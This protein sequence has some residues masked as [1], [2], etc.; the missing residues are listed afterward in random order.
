MN[1]FPRM[2]RLPPYAFNVVGD[3]K[4]ELRH[5]NIDI[6]DLSMGNPDP[7]TPRHIVDKMVEAAQKPVNHR[8]SV[9]RGIPNLR[10][11]ICDWYRRRFGVELN[12]DTQAIAT[13][14]AKEGLSH[15]CLAMLEP[16]DVVFAPDPTYPIHVYAPVICGADVRRV[17]IGEGR[18]FFD[19]LLTATK[20]T[21][22]KPK[23]LIL[24]FPHNPTTQVT[25]LDFFQKVVDF[26][27]EHKIWVI[28]DM[29]YADLVFDGYK[30]P[31]FLQAEGALDVGVEFYS[32]T[33]GYSMA[34]WRVGFCAGNE[35]MIHALTRIKSYLDYGIFQPI[36]IAATVG[37][38]GP[39]EPVRE[40]CDI[41]RKRRD[42][43]CEGLN[44]IG[45]EIEPPKATMFCWGHIPEPYRAMGSMEFSK[46]LLTEGHVAVQPG[47][48]FG[49]YGD[50]Y[51]RFALIENEQRTRQALKGIKK[52]ISG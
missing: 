35:E 42:F 4:K 38:N 3:I 15:L 9:S 36:Q 5:Q 10:K 13:M 34:G 47:I 46:L 21:W 39:E 27:K 50:E 29:A 14:G 22:P 40:I 41:Y 7:P 16:G 43:L 23:L 20:Q 51:V 28:H 44:R 30:A 37:L 26:A 32:M 1:E 33:K 17:P 2:L 49:S 31:S 45:W 25:T 52:V 8:Y 24:S 48:G 19:D 12:P 18:D 6:V 11:A